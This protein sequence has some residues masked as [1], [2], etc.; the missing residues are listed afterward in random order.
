MSALETLEQQLAE[1]WRVMDEVR[2]RYDARRRE[3]EEIARKM[4]Q[5]EMGDEYQKVQEDYSRLSQ[6]CDNER[7]RIAVEKAE[8]VL[9]FPEGTILEKWN[10]PLYD[11]D[12]NRWRRTGRKGVFQIKRDSDDDGWRTAHK[13]SAGAQ[14]VRVLVAG[15][16]PGKRLENYYKRHWLKPGEV[17]PQ[18][19]KS[20]CPS[21]GK[22]RPADGLQSE[23]FR[24]GN[25]CPE[26]GH[27]EPEKGD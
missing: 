4:L 14:V 9:P 15:D 1:S 16:K 21:C 25:V 27:V 10:P 18:A 19:Q 24:P 5:E 7:K 6:A 13:F 17:H 8:A 3:L 2:K 11:W 26:C 20:P 12:S 22:P 23:V